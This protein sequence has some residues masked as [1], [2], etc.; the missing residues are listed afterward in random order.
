VAKRAVS[1]GKQGSLIW[2]QGLACGALVALTP[3]LAF[4]VAILLGPGI[5]AVMLDREP[6]KPIGRAVLLSG[7]AAC[8]TPVRML[9]ASGRGIDAGMAIA[10]DIGVVGTAWS[11]AA[12]GW[13]LAELAPVFV[14]VVLEATSMTRAAQ[15][16][17]S[18][19]RLI[20]E[21]GLAVATPEP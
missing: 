8:V 5:A 6:G 1:D 20:E 13:L 15:L 19:E 11:A 16:R 18:R 17:S 4:M 7:L 3:S 2:V 10:Q 21:W 14:R 9:W 12:G